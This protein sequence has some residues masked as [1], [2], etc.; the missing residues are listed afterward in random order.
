MTPQERVAGFVAARFRAS[1]GKGTV[2]FDEPL[3]SSGIIDSFGL[4][5]VLAFLEDT[6]HVT[7][8]PARH[9]LT[10]LDTVNAMCEVV[11]SLRRTA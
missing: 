5:E 7:I 10:R 3:L 2:G 6:F 11:E 8:D 9:D 1:L 4:L